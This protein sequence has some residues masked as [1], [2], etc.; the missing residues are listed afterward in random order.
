MVIDLANPEQSLATL[1]G[2][3]SEDPASPHY[4]DQMKIWVDG[5]Y[6]PLYF[7]RSPGELPPA[8]IESQLSLEP[9]E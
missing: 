6:L 1:A 9:E 8:E 3:Q 7:C 2:G 5:Q 4:A